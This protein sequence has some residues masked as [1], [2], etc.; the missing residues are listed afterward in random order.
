LWT[1]AHYRIPVVFVIAN[2]RQYKILKDVGP[3]MGL[4]QS[5]AGGHVGL[6]IREPAVDFVGLAESLGVKAIKVDSAVA[7]EERVREGLRGTE[8]LLLEATLAD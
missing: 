1:A 2:N 4:A 7:L 8:P 6:D 3:L 5:T